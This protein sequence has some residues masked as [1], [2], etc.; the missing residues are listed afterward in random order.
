MTNDDQSPSSEFYAPDSEIIK[1]FY[2]RENNEN[3]VNFVLTEDP[4]LACDLKSIIIGFQV[5]VP[6]TC[7][8]DNG[9]ASKLFS[10]LSIEL[11]SQLI[12]NTKST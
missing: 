7:Y 8:P 9:F 3:I 12:T 10:S 2:P 4:N 11:N 5:K 1:T 6:K